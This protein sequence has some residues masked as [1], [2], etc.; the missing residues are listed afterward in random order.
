MRMKIEWYKGIVVSYDVCTS[1]PPLP[2][3]KKS[4][5][6]A[7]QFCDRKTS[8]KRNR[9][10]ENLSYRMQSRRTCTRGDTVTPERPRVTSP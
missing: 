5:L 10:S 8:V 3:K 7:K 1:P 9:V 4:I 6:V 2:L